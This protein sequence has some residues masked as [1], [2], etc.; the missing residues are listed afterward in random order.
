MRDYDEIDELDEGKSQS[1]SNIEKFLQQSNKETSGKN[2]ALSGCFILWFVGSM[3]AMMF[4]NK[5][6][7]KQY[8]TPV[9]LMLF[10]QYFIVFGVLALKGLMQSEDK[11]GNLPMIIFPLVGVLIFGGGLLGLLATMGVLGEGFSDKLVA[12][13]PFIMINLFVI[14]GAAMVIL[15][16]MRNSQLKRECTMEVQAICNKERV[17]HSRNHGRTY[18]PEYLIFI[19]GKEKIIC[20]NFY[21]PIRHTVG[22]VYN[23]IINPNNPNMYIDDTKGANIVIYIVGTVFFIV[24]LLCDYFMFIAN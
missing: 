3:L 8:D 18:S 2:K 7:P 15:C 5:F 9:I 6:V 10:G 12:A 16:F 22:A 4:A 14:V 1:Y 19:D 20:K 21:T 24:G 23:I 13:V 11:M 17:S